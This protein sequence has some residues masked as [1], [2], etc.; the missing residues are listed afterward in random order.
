MSIY[1]YRYSSWLWFGI[2]MGII[3]SKHECGVWMH[4]FWKFILYWKWTI[5]TQVITW[6]RLFLKWFPLVGRYFSCKNCTFIIG[7]EYSI[8]KAICT[9]ECYLYCTMHLCNVCTWF[10]QELCCILWFVY[11]DLL[12]FEY[13]TMCIF[14][15]IVMYEFWDWNWTRWVL[16]EITQNSILL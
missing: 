5:V 2:R 16:S 14:Y 6:T 4:A 1:L 13:L 3:Q 10:P 15:K 11:F 7:E 12:Y 9:E 8:V